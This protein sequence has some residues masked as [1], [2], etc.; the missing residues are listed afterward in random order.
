MLAIS[1]TISNIFAVELCMTLALTF[2]ISKA[3]CIYANRKSICDFL[4]NS[5]CSVF[6]SVTISNIFIQFE[7]LHDSD[8]NH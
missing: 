3:N 2:K 6:L 1:F 5:N 7:N 8:L 4:L